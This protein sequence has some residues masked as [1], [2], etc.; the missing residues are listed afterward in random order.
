L[1]ISKNDIIKLKLK[2][3]K[4]YSY[5]IRVCPGILKKAPD[6]IKNVGLKG[7]FIIITDSNV[8][9]L[10]GDALLKNM[11]DAG[12]Y[13]DKIVFKAGEESK[14]RTTKAFLEDLMFEK[15]YG[16]DSVVI[17]LGGGVTGDMAG[18]VAATFNRGVPFVQIPTTILSMV[19]SSVGGKTG[20]DTKYGK[21]LLGAFCQPKLVIIDPETIKT[22]DKK[23]R[24]NGIAEMI[25]HSVIKDKLLFDELIEN[26]EDI[27]SAKSDVLRRI[28]KSNVAIKAFVVEEDEKETNL[29]KILNFG[30][31]IGHAI[32]LLSNY[33]MG[34]GECVAI[35]MAVEACIAY[36]M[37][38]M[39]ESDYIKIK[40]C[41]KSFGL[42][43]KI[44]GDIK[45]SDII[46]ATTMDKKAQKGKAKY[47]LPALIGFMYEEEGKYAVDVD[48]DVV[49]EAI[50]L[51]S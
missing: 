8:D 36:L 15:G 13:C 21:N 19:D 28:I 43:C 22:L 23:E 49:N 44:P 48:E 6:L 50:E 14:N 24:L 17:A 12:L 5:N 41:I 20:I 2:G 7:R 35:G 33:K 40:E 4:D 29:R 31:T 9:T 42:P 10:Y 37:K 32:E 38:Y 34:H 27:I 45:A 30:H 39:A 46:K 1:D 26:K 11:K 3:V 18:F 25:K 16:R 51:L 47:V